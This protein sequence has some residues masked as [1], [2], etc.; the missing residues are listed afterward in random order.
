MK[1]IYRCLAIALSFSVAHVS[2]LGCSVPDDPTYDSIERQVAML[3]PDTLAQIKRD[4][5]F[6]RFSRWYNQREIYDVRKNPFVAFE[7]NDESGLF[8]NDVAPYYFTLRDVM[9]CMMG[10]ADLQIEWKMFYECLTILENAAKDMHSDLMFEMGFHVDPDE[11]ECS[12]RYVGDFE[13][14]KIPEEEWDPK[15][16]EDSDVSRE[17]VESK[18]PP[19]WVSLIGI[20]VVGGVVVGFSGGAGA[21]LL[22]AL[23]TLGGPEHWSCPTSPGYPPGQTPQPRGDK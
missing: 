11:L 16:I 20:A 19:S 2:T 6:A 17:L 8:E 4:E 23:C 12:Q 9:V 10:P 18:Q 14:K 3:P 5:A 22:P 21:S 13:N 7:C 15:E 1:T